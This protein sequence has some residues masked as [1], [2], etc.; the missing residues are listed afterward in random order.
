MAR[1]R[2]Y[3]EVLG[4]PRTATRKE[5][6]S[7][8]RKLAR[9]FHPDVNPGDKESEARFKEITGA[10]EVLSDA[11]KRKKYD[12]FGENWQAFGQAAQAGGPRPGANMRY[13]QVDPEMFRDLFREADLG[14]MLGGIFGRRS[15]RTGRG[16]AAPPEAESRVQIS[17]Q[18]AFAGTSR[19]VELPDGRRIELTIPPGISSGTVLRVPGLRARVEVAPDPNFEREGKD[20]QVVVNVPLRV[21]LLGG[22]VDVP[23]LKGTKVKLRIPAETQNG[24]RLRLR[25]LGMPDPG[26][27]PPG[28]LLAEVRVRLPLPADEATRRWAEGLPST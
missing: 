18:E 12:Q 28:D 7:A 24:T 23:T 17:L 6:N 11:E 2:D 19:T 26:K 1:V 14:D 9:K 20:V 16:P 22:E 27:G 21:A 15:N 13:Q 5:I 3:Y 8:F 4:V 25:G 10:H